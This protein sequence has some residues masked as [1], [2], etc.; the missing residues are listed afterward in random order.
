M[1]L[2]LRKFALTAHVVCSV[3]WLGAVAAYLSLAVAGVTNPDAQF[4][5]S[6][7]LAMEIIGWLVIVPLSVASLVTG[8]IQSLET[9]WGLIRHYWILEKFVLTLGATTILFLHMPTVGRFSGVAAELIHAGGGLLILL[10]A[11]VL[12]IYK[13]WG[14]TRFG[15]STHHEGHVVAQPATGPAWGMFVLLGTI[16][17]FAF[18]VLAHVAG[19]GH[20]GHFGH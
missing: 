16:G 4:L 19:D 14:R 1:S 8:L 9:D 6:V 11:T 20:R 3:G 7:F 2:G 17:L 5:D 13:P 12:S 10:V 18:I 15:M